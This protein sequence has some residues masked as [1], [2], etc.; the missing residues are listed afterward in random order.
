[1]VINQG[2]IFFINLDPSKGHEQKNRRPVIALSHD[3]LFKTSGMVICAPISN[4]LRSYPMY[5]TLRE[6]KFIQGKVLLDQTRSL[7]PSARGV[8]A[9]DIIEKAS[10]KEFNQIIHRFKLLFDL[11]DQYR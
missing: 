11:I 6:T 9:D 7:D 5:Y 1:M 8:I 3:I 10:F 2:D 4:T